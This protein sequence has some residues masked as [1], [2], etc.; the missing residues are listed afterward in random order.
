MAATQ[1]F[2]QRIKRNEDPRL[3]TGQALFVDDVELPKMVHLMFVRSP[4]AHARILEID[5]E[6]AEAMAGV[7]AVYTAED[8]GDYW[9]PGPLLVPPPPVDG[10][11][12]NQRTQVPLAK[13]K[14][15]YAGEPVAVVVAESRYIAEDA[16]ELVFVDYEILDAVV[17]LEAAISAETPA[18][19]ADIPL[20]KGKFNNVNAHVL[21][22]K[23]KDKNFDSIAATAAAVVKRRYY[24]DHGASCPMETRGVVA[25]WDRR[26]QRMTIWDTTQAPVF[27]RNG[28]AAF[29]GLSEN[30][31]R[32]IAPFIG[33]GF[34]PK[35][36][37]FYPA[38]MLVPWL[39]MQ[40]QR[41]VKWIEDRAEHFVATTQERDQIH[42]A[43][44]AVD[45]Q[46]KILALRD[47]F[48]HD[49]G[50]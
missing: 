28:M 22:I 4:Y 6:D 14:V 3:L 19:H 36:M 24:Y 39:S 5:K 29:L 38:E 26:A 11:I 48:I 31:V 47:Y 12:F 10:M 42:Y 23:G 44:M 45:K 32:V 21:Q 34:G 9:Q 41:P 35:I 20:V 17:D 33:G 16:A 2:G 40:L 1:L 13:G 18:V 37:M 7:I 15:R 8:L 27:I 50:A 43:E 46:G 30:Q 25:D 49:A